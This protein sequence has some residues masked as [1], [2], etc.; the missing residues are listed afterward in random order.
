MPVRK[1]VLLPALAL[2]LCLVSSAAA[3]PG[4]LT[5]LGDTLFPALGNAGYDVQHYDLALRTIVEDGSIRARARIDAVATQ[6]LTLFSLDLLG[7]TV[8]SVL[9]DAQ[10]AV[11]DRQGGELLV[12]PP[13]ALAAGESFSVTVDYHGV[14]APDRYEGLGANLGWNHTDGLIYVVSQPTG[15]RT[16]FPAND[17][18][19]D[20]ATFSL[21]VTVPDGYEVAANGV[22][23]ATEQAGGSTTYRFEMAQPMATYLATVNIGQFERVD[24]MAPNGIPLRD[25][26]PEGVYDAGSDVFAR[27]GEMLALFSDLFGPYP[28]DVYGGVVLN[29]S[30]GFALETQTL[31]VFD[32]SV[33]Y[34]GSFAEAVVAHELAHS[35]FGN[36]VSVADWS[37]IWLN[38]GFATY[39]EWLWFEH[40]DGRAALDEQVRSAYDDMRPAGRRSDLVGA[41]EA[42]NLFSWA[43]YQR[44]GLVLHALRLEVGDARFF[45]ILRTYYARFRDQS[46][47]TADFIAVAEE[48][49]GRALG[50]FF[51]AWLMQP[52]MPAIPRLGLSLAG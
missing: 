26:F 3:Q 45:E 28:F 1:R 20:K 46:V 35:W 25:Y 30:L 16:W 21:A 48:I 39:A 22:L 40:S 32:R 47:R 7:L 50:D 6:P 10:P 12:T 31:S 51:E 14:P 37:D 29:T 33:L 4:D 15:A 11:F 17:H 38:E 36:S 44:G 13:A 42:G 43:V 5:G 52:E 24:R 34:A 19:S 8:D 18:P 41:P 9:V 2:A 49:S 27:A 23:R